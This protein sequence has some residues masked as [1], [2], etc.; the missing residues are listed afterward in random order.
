MKNTL[1]ISAAIS[2]GVGIVAS[3][4]YRVGKVV[5]TAEAALAVMEGVKEAFNN[6][7]TQKK[8]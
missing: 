6:R 8:F 3:V 5:G 4:S 1:L 7:D 2:V